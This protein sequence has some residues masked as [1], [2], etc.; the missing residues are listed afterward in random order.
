MYENIFIVEPGSNAVIFWFKYEEMFFVFGS[1]L[2][3]VAL[4]RMAPVLASASITL[5]QSAL[6]SSSIFAIACSTKS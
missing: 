1:K 3:Y 5:T 2:G 6:L 4:A